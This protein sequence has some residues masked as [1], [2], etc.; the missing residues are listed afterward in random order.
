MPRWKPKP[1]PS[2]EGLRA[3]F[4][5]VPETG[6]LI[7]KRR[8]VKSRSDFGFNNKC[9]GKVAG[10]V[11]G[12]EGNQYIHVGIGKVYYQAHR[13]IWKMVTGEEPPEFIDHKDGNNLNNRWPNFRA[14]DNGTNLQNAKLRKD[15]ISGVKGVSWDAGHKMWRVTIAV[16]KKYYRFGRF[17]TVEEAKAV[18]DQKRQELH[19]EF[20]RQQ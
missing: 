6:L 14:A 11:T 18:I 12:R 17:S 15:N 20:A 16:N 10:T 13:I 3:I 19:G 5:Y 9:G 1:L 2:A 8:E 4:E 7:W